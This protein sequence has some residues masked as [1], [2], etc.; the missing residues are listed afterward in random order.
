MGLLRKAANTATPGDTQAAFSPS[1]ESYGERTEARA[2]G[3]L[4]KSIEALSTRIT[5]GIAEPPFEQPPAGS[6]SVELAPM[7]T[8]TGPL[9]DA[10]EEDGHAPPPEAHPTERETTEILEA[11]R[12]LPGGV[13]LP[14]LLFSTVASR[15]SVAKGA[16]LLYDP[17]RLVY[18]P[19]ASRGYDQ[20]SLHRMRIP[21]GANESFNAL[22]NGAPLALTDGA[23]IG[24]YQRYFSAREFAGCSRIVLTP[25]IAEAKLIGVLLLSELRPP[26]EGNVELLRSLGRIAE[27]G[28]PLV[29]KA[30]VER[31]A[32]AGT[33]GLPAAQSPGEEI[34]RL[35]SD[36]GASGAP[37]LFL[38]LSLDE[39]ARAT[40]E[41]HEH[42]D[43]FRLHEDMK[44]F[45]DA[46]VADLGVALPVRQGQYIVGLQGFEV[47]DL[48][49][50]LHQLTSF[51]DG[52]FRA[53]GRSAAGQA[54]RILK[55]R[56][57]PS[58]G[59][60]PQELVDFLSA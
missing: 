24:A 6:L 55:V 26:F 38:S 9:A 14:S 35:V 30:R 59:D 5:A 45:L 28:S 43:P 11:I 52:L 46:F 3:L 48:D 42:L 40:I 33:Q 18:A 34:A 47:G 36:S 12:R 57:W 37:I 15:L 51:L 50:F 29:Q 21:L 17:V 4:Q 7:E 2:S 53:N 41:A 8:G 44:Y 27:E 56:S 10:V 19:W 25:F 49:L 13:E 23:S 39:F 16:L 20:T 60:D 58:D 31:L 32:R 54:P 22:A 1:P